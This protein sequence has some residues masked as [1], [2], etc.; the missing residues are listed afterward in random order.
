M[1][2]SLI[3]QFNEIMDDNRIIIYDVTNNDAEIRKKHIIEGVFRTTSGLITRMNGSENII[4]YNF[5]LDF[6]VP[7]DD[8]DLRNE[9]EE[10]IKQFRI[11][12]DNVLIDYFRVQ[13]SIEVAIGNEYSYRDNSGR[14]RDYVTYYIVGTLSY[15]GDFVG[16]EN[17]EISINNNDL[18]GILT[19]VVTFNNNLVTNTIVKNNENLNTPNEYNTNDYV[20]AYS[21]TI[22][23]SVNNGCKFLYD[24]YNN[25]YKIKNTFDFKYVWKDD[26]GNVLI[27][28]N[29]RI[30]IQG[31]DMAQS[32]GSL[33]S[34]VVRA[35]D[36]YERN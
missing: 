34:L 19:C 18:I 26:N 36:T 24:L 8:V 17:I 12:I 11:N 33:S 1:F 28:I 29:S 4:N 22:Q 30:K 5:K 7:V 15:V 13:P 23:A 16:M 10:K 2:E 31:I 20:R 3:S 6:A 25:P 35:V 21:I 27:N 32:Y 14:F 9:I